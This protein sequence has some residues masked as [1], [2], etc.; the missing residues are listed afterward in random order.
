M[1]ETLIAILL[2]IFLVL[3]PLVI[4]FVQNQTIFKTI[5]ITLFIFYLIVLFANTTGS[6]RFQNNSVT[7]EVILK[8]GWFDKEILMTWIPNEFGD[9][10]RNI[11]M[12]V[13]LGTF[14]TLIK[15]SSFKKTMLITV[16]V[17]FCTSFLIEFL[18]FM[19]PIHRWPQISDVI[20]NTLS[21]II[22]AIFAFICLKIKGKI[23]KNKKQ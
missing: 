6:M 5:I 14:T 11:I 15:P 8:G 23:F 9:F 21:A 18:Q 16:I 2:I 13:P 22:G 19:L 1:T 17:A 7:I 20:F 4:I 12:F 10:Y 3:A